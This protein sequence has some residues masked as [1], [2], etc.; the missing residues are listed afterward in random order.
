MPLP[1][2]ETIKGL[3]TKTVLLRARVVLQC[4]KDIPQCITQRGVPREDNRQ[5]S[6]KARCVNV[7]FKIQLVDNQ[8]Y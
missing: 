2:L 3:D 7:P 1:Q 8:N 5:Y 6:Y 4:F